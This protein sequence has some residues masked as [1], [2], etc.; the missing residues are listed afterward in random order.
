MPTLILFATLSLL[1]A[2]LLAKG[3]R[4]VKQSEAM[5]V[6]RL[7]KYHRKME[8]GLHLLIPFFLVQDQ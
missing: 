3:I 2:V 1:V 8:A 4:I 7:G 6:E 5:I